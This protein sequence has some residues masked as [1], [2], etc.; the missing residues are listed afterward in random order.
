[1]FVVREKTSQINATCGCG[2]C[3]GECIRNVCAGLVPTD[4]YLV[5]HGFIVSDEHTSCREDRGVPVDRLVPQW[6]AIVESQTLSLEWGLDEVPFV[7]ADCLGNRTHG[8]PKRAVLGLLE[9]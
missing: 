8:L 4:R 3:V 5:Y 2:G 9:D 6:R 1:M 7:F